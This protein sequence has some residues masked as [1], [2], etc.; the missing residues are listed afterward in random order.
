MNI[1]LLGSGG[2]ESALA[3]KIKQSKHCDTLYIAPGNG[4]TAQYGIN[5]D[6]GILDFEAINT[7]CVDHQVHII[8]CGPELPAV[9]GL[10]DYFK[11]N[12]SILVIAPSQVSA[13]LEGSKAFAKEFMQKHHI[14]TAE[15]IEVD[16]D[17]IEEGFH[18]FE[19]KNAPYVIKA[20]GLAE[21]KGVVIAT[22]KEEAKSTLIDFVQNQKFGASSAKVVLEEFLDGIEFSMFVFTNGKKYVML[23]NAKDYKRR[24]E[25]N[26]GLN[27]GGMGCISPVP[28]VDKEMEEKVKTQVIEPTIKGL[29]EDNM[30][31]FGFIYFGLINVDGQPKVIE[32]NCRLGDPETEVLMPRI[33]SDLI[34]MFWAGVEDKSEVAGFD[35]LGSIGF[36]LE[37]FEVNISNQHCATVMLASN[38]YPEAYLKGFEISGLEKV[39]E[40]IVFHAGTKSIDSKCVTNG[41][42]V[43]AIS[44]LGNSLKNAL[45]LSYQSVN[46]IQFQGKVYRNDIGFEFF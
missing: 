13:Q 5:V 32:Y 33:E 27:T 34:E 4:G 17:N 29:Q 15:Y 44:S 9:H 3:W 28:F 2:R 25:G 40:S 1:L 45:E 11:S 12:K 38:G 31:Y 14:P 24:F 23:P 41:G 26:I 8:V 42:R 20:D 10:W 16:R 36:S 7:F 22:N 39:K 43:M 30:P 35:V 37:N 46:L 21:G 19:T 6:L 18:W